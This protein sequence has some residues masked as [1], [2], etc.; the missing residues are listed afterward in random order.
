MEQT[1]DKAEPQAPGNDGQPNHAEIKP[2]TPSGSPRTGSKRRLASDPASPTPSPGSPAIPFDMMGPDFPL[3]PPEGVHPMMWRLLT[4][5]QKDVS[6]LDDI[7]NRV[8]VMEDLVDNNGSDISMLKNTVELL[9]ASDKTLSGRLLRAEAVF[10][11]Q[12]QEIT[13]LKCRSMRDNLI[14]KTSGEKYKE[15]KNENTDTTVRKFLREELRIPDTEGIQINSS[16]RMGQA[17]AAYNRMLIARLPKRRDHTKV[18]DNVKA[19]QGTTF[20]ISKQVPAEIDERRQFAWAEYKEAKSEKKPARFDG[21]TLVVGG[22]P[23]KRYNP[24]QLPISSNV[25]QQR[26]S[27]SLAVGTSDVVADGSH[28]FQAWASPA[29]STYDVR[30]AYDQLLHFPELAGA[31]HAPYA[32]RFQGAGSNPQEIFFSDGDTNAGVMMVRIIRELSAENLVVFV[33]HYTGEHPTSLSRKKKVECLAS[34]IGG[35]V[36]SITAAEKPK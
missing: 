33:A 26:C 30:E 10:T 8:A 12:Q 11:R 18:F 19:L 24:V 4:T 1:T 7:P 13:D 21:G 27:P 9:V 20:S 17:T 28:T 32:F 16:H 2:A 15:L 29:Y 25:L 3:N 14:I 23:I 6:K 22:E 35:A 5:I 31:T 36:M 34:V